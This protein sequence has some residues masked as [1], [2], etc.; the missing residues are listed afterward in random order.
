MPTGKLVRVKDFLPSPLRL[1]KKEK[2][3]ENALIRGEYRNIGK[4]D[5]KRISGILKTHKMKTMRTECDL[6]KLK[7]HRNP[8]A[9]ALNE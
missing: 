7:G 9:E 2:Q 3:I 1:T 5:F 6:T 4:K 8:Y